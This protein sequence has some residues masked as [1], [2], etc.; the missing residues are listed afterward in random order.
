MQ[1]PSFEQMQPG[2]TFG[3]LRKGPMSTAHVMR[4]SA[5]VENF[6]RIHYDLPFATGHDGLPGI[7]VNGSWKQHVLVQLLKDVAGPAGW[8]WRMGFR[9]KA[10]DLAGDTILVQARVASTTTLDG[11]GFVGLQVLQS[12]QKGGASTVGA[13]LLV[14]PLQGGRPVPYPFEAKPAYEAVALPAYWDA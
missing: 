7:P 6:H 9:Y 1:A 8:L 10:M 2:V 11:L 13:A 12:T 4:W 3:P 14:M 5:A